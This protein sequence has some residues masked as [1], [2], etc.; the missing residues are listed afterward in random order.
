MNAV[1]CMALQR[2]MI[3]FFPMPISVKEI[4]GRK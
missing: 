4:H 3:Y 1:A 2:S